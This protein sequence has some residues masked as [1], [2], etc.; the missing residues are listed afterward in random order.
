MAALLDI[1]KR[2]DK[3]KEPEKKEAEK[4]VEEKPEA[5]EA[6]PVKKVKGKKAEDASPYAVINHQH[7][8]EKA[9]DLMGLNKYTFKVFSNANKNTVKKAIEKLYGVKVKG[10]N[11]VT[12]PSKSVRLGR[13][14]G[15]KGGFKKAIVTLH[16]GQKIEIAPH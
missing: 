12:L 10:V 3:K 4:K 9:S 16:E 15:V 1:F 14:E 6:K 8:T 5:R 2:K 13:H 11:I 7:I